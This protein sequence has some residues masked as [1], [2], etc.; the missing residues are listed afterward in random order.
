MKQRYFS[1][2]PGKTNI[3]LVVP[4]GHMDGNYRDDE[5]TLEIAVE[6]QKRLNCYV[7]G[8][9]V[10]RKPRK[11]EKLNTEEK[12]CNLN[13]LTDY[14]ETAPE[15]YKAF[16][17]TIRQ[18]KEKIK[19]SGKTPYIFHL[20]GASGKN[21]NNACREVQKSG[22]KSVGILI[23]TG[24][25]TTK[26]ADNE[27]LTASMS[28][29]N[30]LIAC[31]DSEGI[32][33]YS[34]NNSLYAARAS[35]NLCQLFTKHYPDDTVESFQ[36][37]IRKEGYRE[38]G[39]YSYTAEK[40]S[41][42]FKKIDGVSVEQ[43]TQAL[44]TYEADRGAQE[45]IDLAVEF[46]VNTYQDAAKAALLRVGHYLVETFFGGDYRSAANPRNIRGSKSL[47]SIR[48][49]L[50][51]ATGSPSRTWVYDA[52]KVTVDDYFILEKDNFQTYG[53]LSVS[54][55]VK[56]TSVGDNI[57]LKKELAELS[58]S[59]KWSVRELSEQINQR[60][61]GQLSLFKQLS[62]TLL[63]QERFEQSLEDNSFFEV[64]DALP[65]KKKQILRG[66]AVDR[67]EMI[68]RKIAELERLNKLYRK[69]GSR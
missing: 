12:I 63:S 47:N 31:L 58:V 2:I 26:Y 64:F 30:S 23:G 54:H 32:R 44:T 8:N 37:E 39:N 41:N 45:K 21:F 59:E 67:A 61:A 13:K 28:S 51:L 1:A 60:K 49:K 27:S 3:I 62:S 25:G 11:K 18:Y 68:G 9:N 36:L 5:F 10:F 50:E 24:R 34:T 38:Q 43:F 7:V 53:K 65:E 33:S 14:R 52:L 4:H 15:L 66:K 69:I 46:I 17:G 16:V 42:A 55:R 56:L 29:L 22:F 57:E 35:H 20:H 19:K 48:Q 40:L 6:I